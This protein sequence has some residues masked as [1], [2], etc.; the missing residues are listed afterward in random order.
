MTKDTVYNTNGSI[1]GQILQIQHFCVDDGPGIRTTVFLK[2][3]PLRCAWCHNP[4]SHKQTDEVMFYRDRCRSCGRCVSLC[5]HHAH[6]ITPDGIHKYDR[7]AC[8]MCGACIQP[9]PGNALEKAGE[10]QTVDQVLTEI[11]T[12]SI[13]YRTSGGGITISGGEPTAQPAFTEALLSACKQEGFHTCIET[14]GWCAPHVLERL[15][16]L[17]D[18]FLLDW[19]ITDDKLHE[20][21]TGV[22]N[23]P[24]LRNLARL[25]EHKAP[26]VLRCPLIPDVNLDASHYDGIVR[27]VQR[28]PNIQQVDLEPYHPMGLSKMSALGRVS[29]YDHKEFLPKD[30][31]KEV[32]RII[33]AQISIPV[34]ISGT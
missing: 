13:F 21:Y 25:S 3:C 9:C 1:T 14:C 33:S 10:R 23:Q 28:Y 17:V 4:E 26:V 7:T 12:D 2:G 24:I 31:A 8:V 5:E 29:T 16:P 30:W 32:Q 11:R 19:K 22:S 15:I 34:R 18:L 6:T 20:R 27:L